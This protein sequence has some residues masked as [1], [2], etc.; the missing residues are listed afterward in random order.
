[1]DLVTLAGLAQWMDYALRRVGQEHVGTLLEVSALTGR[2]S[3]ESKDIL[4]AMVPLFADRDAENP[5][6][7]K[8]LVGILGQLDAL[9]GQ[10]DSNEIKLLSFLLQDDSEVFPLIRP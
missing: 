2:I 3:D 6:T 4:L 7:A 5:I 8:S 9:M 10:A 1:M